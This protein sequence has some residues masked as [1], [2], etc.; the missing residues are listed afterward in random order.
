MSWKSSKKKK[1]ETKKKGSDLYALL[2]LKNERFLATPNQLKNGGLTW[3]REPKHI[4]IVFKV[5]NMFHFP[6]AHVAAYRKVCLESHPDKRLVGVEDEEEKEQIE[7]YFKQI[8][9]AYAV[10]GGSPSSRYIKSH[11][12]HY[13]CKQIIS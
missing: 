11:L 8:Q 10:S 13:Y 4:P 7:E 5:S 3:P 1:K 2:G 9:D 6:Y 12:K